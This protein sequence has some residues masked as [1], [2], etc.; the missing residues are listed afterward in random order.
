MCTLPP[1]CLVPTC[2]PPAPLSRFFLSWL[3][4]VGMFSALK[5]AGQK[6]KT[7]TKK[8]LKE[9]ET[10]ESLRTIMMLVP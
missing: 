3:D 5:E 10:R 9:R 8:K 1:R 7:K 2:V 6:D 4:R